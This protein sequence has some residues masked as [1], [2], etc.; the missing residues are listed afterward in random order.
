MYVELNP[1]F[2]ILMALLA[3]LLAVALVRRMG[4]VGWLALG[5][6]LLVCA[7]MNPDRAQHMMAVRQQASAGPASEA[8]GW[9]PADLMALFRSGRFEPLTDYHN[10]GIASVVTIQG[11]AL[12]F[13]MLG[14]VWVVKLQRL[15]HR[16]GRDGADDRGSH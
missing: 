12:S 10:L 3:A 7:G 4:L 9:R 2:L 13:G 5:V 15:A 11:K 8:T 16:P 1:V 6:A 14:E